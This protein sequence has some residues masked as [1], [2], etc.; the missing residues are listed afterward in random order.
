MDALADAA[1]RLGARGARLVLTTSAYS[2]IVFQPSAARAQTDC[3]NTVTR[4]FAPTHPGVGLIDLAEYVCPSGGTCRDTIDGAK[5]RADGVHYE[6]RAARLIAR[7]MLPQLG[8]PGAG[9]GP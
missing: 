3:T 7:W 6:G 9:D 1:D 5:L 8:F 2:Q 4:E